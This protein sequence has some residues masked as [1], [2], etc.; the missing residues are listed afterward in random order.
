MI[1]ITNPTIS[2]YAELEDVVVHTPPPMTNDISSTPDPKHPNT[3]IKKF[4]YLIAAIRCLPSTLNDA[5][6]TV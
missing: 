4:M 3:I 2:K 1:T 5:E 6:Q